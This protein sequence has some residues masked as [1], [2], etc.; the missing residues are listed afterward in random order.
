MKNNLLKKLLILPVFLLTVGMMYG[1]TV[2][3]GVVSDSSGTLP[4]VSVVEKGSTNGT[5][6]DF[7]GSY[8]ITLKS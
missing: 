4:G 5:Q 7:N 6:T 8:S 2:V 1:Q 3:K